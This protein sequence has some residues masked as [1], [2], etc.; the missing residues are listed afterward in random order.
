[1]ASEYE[2]GMS[3]PTI[4]GALD[5][6]PS[7]YGPFPNH[8]T[9]IEDDGV[10]LPVLDAQ[11]CEM[12]QGVTWDSLISS[13]GY[14]HYE[15]RVELTSAARDGCRL[16]LWICKALHLTN[17]VPSPT[18]VRLKPFSLVFDS[19]NC[20]LAIQEPNMAPRTILSLFFDIPISNLSIAERVGNEGKSWRMKHHQMAIHKFQ[21]VVWISYILVVE[22]LEER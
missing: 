22:G 16:C 8:D 12:C 11:L 7:I 2:P 20:A 1:M 19:Y 14:M 6:K 18:H 15:R 4:S 21:S 17:H 13:S 5:W 9:I 10:N 3:F